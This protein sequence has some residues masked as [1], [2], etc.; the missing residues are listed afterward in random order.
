MSL[1]GSIASTPGLKPNNTHSVCA[2]NGP[3]TR[4]HSLV[5]HTRAPSVFIAVALLAFQDQERER[6]KKIPNRTRTRDAS[7]HVTIANATK[8]RAHRSPVGSFA[9]LRIPFYACISKPYERASVFMF[10]RRRARA[11]EFFNFSV[12][13]TRMRGMHLNIQTSENVL[14][15]GG[16]QK[17]R[18]GEGTAEHTVNHRNRQ[19]QFYVGWR[20]ADL[21]AAAFVRTSLTLGRIER[22]SCTRTRTHIV[23]PV[24]GEI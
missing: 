9:L 21:C 1:I 13:G 4:A 18:G 5:M 19:N 20:L 7:K 11:P 2:N 23:G 17:T 12:F 8:D 24:N 22:R 6:A 14:Q 10:T 15:G 16:G 3:C